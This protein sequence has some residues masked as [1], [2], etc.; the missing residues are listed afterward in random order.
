MKH[1]PVE[2]RPF[3]TLAESLSDD[4]RAVAEGRRQSTSELKAFGD[5]L[6]ASLASLDDDLAEKN[7]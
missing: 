7:A 2:R 5:Q 3:G 1:E 6:R 4:V